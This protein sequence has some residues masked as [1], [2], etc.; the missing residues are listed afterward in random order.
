MIILK[1]SGK[2]LEERKDE[3]DNTGGVILFVAI[4]TFLF[5]LILMNGIMM[6]VAAIIGV[7][8]ANVLSARIGY[9]KGA[10]GEKK[11]TE[12][13]MKLSDDYFLLNDVKIPGT[14]GNIDHVVLGPGSVFCIETKNMKGI[15]AC[16]EDSWYKITPFKRKRYEIR[17]ISRQLNGNSI[18]L[19]KFLN[20]EFGRVN[21]VNGLLVFSDPE[22]ELDLKYCKVNYTKIGGML[23]EIEAKNQ[24][25]K[26]TKVELRAIGDFLLKKSV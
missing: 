15:V 5:A 19:K 6:I 10:Q 21:W 4:V 13:L 11:V 23:K 14:Y 3:A 25:R 20:S 17:S 22:V 18:R 16:Y 12:E 26:F 9:A 24:Y 1:E 2:W 7:Y 8:G